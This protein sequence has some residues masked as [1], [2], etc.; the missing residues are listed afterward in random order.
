MVEDQLKIIQFKEW[1]ENKIKD[2][3]QTLR[4]M[5]DNIK[6]SN[7]CICEVPADKR[8]NGREWIQNIIPEVWKHTSDFKILVELIHRKL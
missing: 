3:E 4:D 8:E 5:W 6:L 1:R 7:I 2:K